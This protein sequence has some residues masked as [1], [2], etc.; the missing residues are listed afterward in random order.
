M[1]AFA[2]FSAAVGLAV[3]AAC[4]GGGHSGSSGPVAASSSVAMLEGSTLLE[5]VLAI[6][7]EAA[8]PATVSVTSAPRHG[9][10]SVDPDQRVRY[11]PDPRFNGADQ[12]DYRIVPA[13]GSPLTGPLT[14]TVPLPVPRLSSQTRP[15]CC[16]PR[17][18]SLPARSPCS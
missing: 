13:S 5:N 12:L 6:H 7:P 18:R 4:G 17:P 9:V 11:D 3:L 1:K 10:A 2:R 16:S 8:L 15:P 14:I